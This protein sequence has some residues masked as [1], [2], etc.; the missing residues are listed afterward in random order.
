MMKLLGRLQGGVPEE[1]GWWYLAVYW[2]GKRCQY[3]PWH[4]HTDTGCSRG[5]RLGRFMF[6]H[7]RRNLTHVVRSVAGF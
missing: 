2:L 1:G 7:R 5:L 3:V 6:V 4:I